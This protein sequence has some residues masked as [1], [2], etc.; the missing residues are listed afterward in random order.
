MDTPTLALA[1]K[2]ASEIARQVSAEVAERV[3]RS[4][5]PEKGDPGYTPIKGKDYFD[6]K[7]AYVPKKGVD[8]FDGDP[9]Y[10][11]VKGKDYDD[12]KPGKDANRWHLVYGEPDDDFGDDDDFALDGNNSNV[13]QKQAG[14]WE[15]ILH[16]KSETPSLQMQ[17]PAVLSEQRITSI[18]N[19]IISSGPDITYKDADFTAG[20]Q[21]EIIHVGASCTISLPPP[22]GN[23]GK[24]YEV[25]RLTTAGVVTVDTVSGNSQDFDYRHECQKITQDRWSIRVVSDGGTWL[26]VH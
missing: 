21:N 1:I 23:K 5:V 10:T 9:G 4:I 20:L 14:E 2:K 11:P 18:I 24:Y 22:Q 16:L 15:F 7:D 19:S 13:Y 12:G 3:A 17:P 26:V 6:G 8:Y 25:K